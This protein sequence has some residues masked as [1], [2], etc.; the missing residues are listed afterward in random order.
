M[1]GVLRCRVL[2]CTATGRRRG[3]EAEAGKRTNRCLSDAARAAAILE[4][5]Q[6]RE[7]AVHNTPTSP[8][9]VL[10]P[11]CRRPLTWAPDRWLGTFDCERCGEFSDFASA[12]HSPRRLP[13]TLRGFDGPDDPL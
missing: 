9:T 4:C 8:G 10:C 7:D 3:R 6:P 2:D 12:A 1:P 13:I 11:I 5:R